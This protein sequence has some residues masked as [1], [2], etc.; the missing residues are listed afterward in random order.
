QEYTKHGT[1]SPELNKRTEISIIHSGR[2]SNFS[3]QRIY[4]APVERE[5]IEE[6]LA[7]GT[8]VIVL[9]TIPNSHCRAWNC[10]PRELSS[11]PNI[12]SDFRFNLRDLSSR[13]YGIFN[14]LLTKREQGSNHYYHII[15]MEQIFGDLAPLYNK[16]LKEWIETSSIIEISHQ[17]K[18]HVGD[19]KDCEQCENIPVEPRKNEYF[20]DEHTGLLTE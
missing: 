20:P 19:L 18:N 4:D 8:F 7:S 1:S 13:R 14:L 16:V 3:L 2:S 5:N 12:C 9:Q 10:L 11:R 15:C 17:V 6:K